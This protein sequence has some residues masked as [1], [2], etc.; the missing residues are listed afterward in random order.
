MKSKSPAPTK[1]P[2]S[3]KKKFKC[4]G[5]G[6]CKMAFTRQEHLARHQRRHTGEKPFQCEICLKFFSRFDN[7]NQH[8]DAVHLTRRSGS[9]K[10]FIIEQNIHSSM[11]M[12][13]SDSTM[14]LNTQQY[15][16]QNPS[17]L[18]VCQHTTPHQ[19]N[20]MVQSVLQHP[21]F[22]RSSSPLLRSQS[23]LQ[24]QAKSL[25]TPQLVRRTSP[26]PY[27]HPQQQFM[28]PMPQTYIDTPRGTNSPVSMMGGASGLR[29]IK[30]PPIIFNTAETNS[31]PKDSISAPA[32]NPYRPHSP[33]DQTT[34]SSMRVLAP[35]HNN[36]NPNS[37]NNLNMSSTSN[38]A[39]SNV[40]LPMLSTALGDHASNIIS[41]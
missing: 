31:M 40:R 9:A 21:S 11:N 35:H 22:Q 18:S 5:F 39:N 27:L 24:P 25:P 29:H 30:L 38:Q 19:N 20:V 12:L 23:L 14:Q 3:N 37:F 28:A 33:L 16:M 15:M 7:M 17:Y 8:R 36:T 13:P 1:R 32:I 34:L 4:E 2:A 6:E 26:L 41:R 10:Q